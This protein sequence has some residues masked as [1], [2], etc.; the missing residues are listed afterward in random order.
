MDEFTLTPRIP[1]RFY[2]PNVHNVGPPSMHDILCM[3]PSYWPFKMGPLTKFLSP[4]FSCLA[5]D[6]YDNLFLVILYLRVNNMSQFL[7]LNKSLKYGY[8]HK[9]MD[10]G[11]CVENWDNLFA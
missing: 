8:N 2:K 7:S 3:D 11:T 1:S 6:G 10:I 9:N 5:H 4:R